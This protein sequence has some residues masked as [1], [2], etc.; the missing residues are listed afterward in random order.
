MSAPASR[1]S[2]PSNG[3]WTDRHDGMDDG[4]LLRG[5]ARQIRMQSTSAGA[6]ASWRT[7]R[8][9]EIVAPHRRR[10]PRMKASVVD[11][12]DLLGFEN[13]MRI[14]GGGAK[15]GQRGVTCA[16]VAAAPS[17]S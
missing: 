9:L 6:A 12:G 8:R 14:G 2:C 13:V 4:G 11:R 1:S 17:G 10:P 3:T 15:R 7:A 5:D 16:T